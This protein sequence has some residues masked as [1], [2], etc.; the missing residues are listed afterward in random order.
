MR[1]S[2]VMFVAVVALLAPVA[3]FA[4]TAPT[5]AQTASSIC[6]GLQKQL[7]TTFAKTYANFGACVKANQ[8]H[9]NQDVQNANA[10]CKKEQSDPTGFAAA[11]GGKTF[12]QVYGSN[13]A[14][15]K[16]ADANA[17]GKCVSQHVQQSAQQDV[18]ATVNA[19][20]T[21]KAMLKN[22]PTGFATAFGKTKNA[23]GKCVKAKGKTP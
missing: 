4:D 22:N 15:G 2:I 10:T 16:G 18:Q 11:N 7:G 9:A 17:F 1:K 3:A 13:N 6:K 23:F 12:D 20:K 8:Q 21:C 19:A 14:K 5:P